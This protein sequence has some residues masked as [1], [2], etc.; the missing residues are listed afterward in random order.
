[1]NMCT[2]EFVWIY[3][4]LCHKTRAPGKCKFFMWLVLHD[5][6]WTAIRRKLHGLQNDDTCV[7]CC[8]LS[9]T[10]DHLLIG[11]SFSREVWFKALQWM[12]WEAVAPTTQTAGLADWWTT[13]RKI[14]PKDERR[15]FDTLLILI[16]WLLWKES[17]PTGANGWCCT[18]E[19]SW[20]GVVLVSGRV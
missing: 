11:C 9:E 20:W 15:C 10:I 8:Q 14:I 4:S 19:D 6:C 17:R 5:R 1:M 7:L 16:C 13:A 18:N 2:S 12:R 3:L